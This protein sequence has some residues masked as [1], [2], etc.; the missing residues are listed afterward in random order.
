MKCVGFHI[1]ITESRRILHGILHIPPKTPSHPTP[2]PHPYMTRRSRLFGKRIDPD[3]EEMVRS[4]ASAEHAGGGVIPGQCLCA[5]ADGSGVAVA[6]AAAAA[7][8]GHPRRAAAALPTQ[9]RAPPPAHL[10]MTRKIDRRRAGGG[11]RRRSGS[12]SS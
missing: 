5:V 9:L 4:C 11:G 8:A 2:N 10:H 7:L 3:I 6:A 12:G 1:E